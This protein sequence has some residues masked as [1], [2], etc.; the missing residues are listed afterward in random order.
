M[1]KLKIVH[2]IQLIDTG[3]AEKMILDLA[4]NSNP[5]HD[6]TIICQYPSGNY[7]Y[8]KIARENNIK[9]IF[10]HKKVGF[11]L[12]SFIELW[13][14]L[15][16][17]K[18]N[19]VHTHLQAAVY[20]LPWLVFHRKNARIHT[21]HSIATME[22]RKTH[23][24]IQR[25]AYKFWN[26]VP[27]AI[28]RTVQN[29]VMNEYK[30]PKEKVPIISNGIDTKKFPPIASNVDNEIFTIINV[31]SFSKWKN[32]ILLV[33]ALNIA[34]LENP[35]LKLIFA[36]DGKER[37]NVEAKA[38]KYNISEKIVFVGATSEVY[39]WLSLA[40]VFI[41][42]STFE[43]IPLSIIEAMSSG[44]PIIATDV[45]GIPDITE[46]NE[47]GL[48]VPPNDAKAL[49]LAILKMANDKDMQYRISK[50]NIEKSKKFDI[51]NITDEYINLYKKKLGEIN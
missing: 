9:L 22:V 23:R 14:T 42:C 18:P 35:N 8:E 43:G 51:S 28:S 27:V 17:I 21:I 5:K 34:L 38:R 3:G 10:L 50:N 6:V 24:I 30:L 15:S 4:I 32:Q 37:V 33:E 41:L 19:V 11:D 39:K 12:Y 1:D 29:G 20:A 31:A 46:N 44:L 13:Q 25:F 26:V 49:A 16:K 48:L 45:G 47:S 40:N 7:P 2:I 36:G